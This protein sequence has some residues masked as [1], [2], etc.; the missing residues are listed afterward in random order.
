MKKLL[1]SLG[2]L[3]S[4]ILFS[5]LH[6][7]PGYII[8]NNGN[9]TI[10]LIKNL[11][12]KDNPAQFYYKLPNS[13]EIKTG[14]TANIKEFGVDNNLKYIREKVK[15][16]TSTNDINNVSNTKE[17][18][19]REETI[20]LK[21][22]IEG[23][24]NLYAYEKGRLLRFFYSTTDDSE[25]KPLIYKLYYTDTDKIA[26][27]EEYIE[28][29]SKLPKCTITKNDLNKLKYTEH[30]L[31]NIF[32]KSNQC[33]T[34]ENIVNKNYV[35]QKNKKD[36]FNLSINPGINLSKLSVSSG[37]V[38]N[39]DIDFDNEIAFRVGVEMEMFLPFNNNK[40]AI[41]A[42]PFYQSY[43]TSKVVS[44]PRIYSA[45]VD[46][47]WSTKH[48]SINLALGIRR[49]FPFKRSITTFCRCIIYSF[50]IF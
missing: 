23:N 44:S 33:S 45:P 48:S 49:Y 13:E 24:A 41:L 32:N 7:E 10:A 6:F 35:I 11:D 36:R 20:Y 42:E 22:I 26:Y 12:W 3:N 16:D 8:D 25:I 39:R 34:N 15:L 38:D 29:I 37:L 43:K 40:W 4:A 2:I 14:S 28:Q 19:F 30:D 47:T 5:Q 46:E 18:Q 27:N 9:R 21:T 17:P 50:S 31:V 1:F